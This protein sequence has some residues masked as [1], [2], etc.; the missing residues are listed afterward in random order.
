MLVADVDIANTALALLGIPG[1]SSLA[2]DKP[3][4]RAMQRSYPVQLVAELR[5]HRWSFAMK[6]TP[7]A[8]NAT[9]PAFEYAAQYP[10]PSDCVRLDYIGDWYAGGISV[11]YANANN[12][13]YRIEGRAILSNVTGTLN[14]RYI[15]SITDSGLFDPLFVIALAARMA[16][17][18]CLLLTE[19]NTK[20]QDINNEYR[21]AITL[22]VQTNAIEKAPQQLPDGSWIIG[23][24]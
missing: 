6:R 9:P 20:K 10:I 2:D 3:S 1:I 13:D 5:A 22:A 17:A 16:K 15:A 19:S 14:I 21:D 24:L 8:A 18:N 23:R 4:A 11:D 7:L 12:A